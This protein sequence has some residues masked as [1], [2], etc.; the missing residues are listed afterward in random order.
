MEAR[1]SEPARP[2]RDAGKKR[3]LNNRPIKR[4]IPKDVDSV[5]CHG[6]AANA[7]AAFW[8]GII[9]QGDERGY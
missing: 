2:R 5:F 7:S 9:L 8:K 1:Q 3:P 4:S 6:I